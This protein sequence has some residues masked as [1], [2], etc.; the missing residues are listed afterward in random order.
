MVSSSKKRAV[1]L[2]ARIGKLGDLASTY[3]TDRSSFDAKEVAAPGPWIANQLVKM[4]SVPSDLAEQLL[5]TGRLRGHKRPDSGILHAHPRFRDEER[6]L[7]A[8]Q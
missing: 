3:R 4:R 2:R 6:S 1:L 5:Q 7:R 8:T